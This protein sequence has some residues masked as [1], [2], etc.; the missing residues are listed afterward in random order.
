V[1][2]IVAG[3]QLVAIAA[4]FALRPILT[5]WLQDRTSGWRAVA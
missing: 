1:N 2:W 3:G 4:M 5:R